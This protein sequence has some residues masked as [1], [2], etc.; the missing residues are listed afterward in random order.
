MRMDGVKGRISSVLGDHNWAWVVYHMPFFKLVIFSLFDISVEDTIQ[1]TNK[2]VVG[3]LE[4][5]G[6]GLR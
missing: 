2:N 1:H 3:S 4:D 5:F 6:F